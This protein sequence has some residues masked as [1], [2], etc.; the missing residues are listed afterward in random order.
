M[1]VGGHM[2]CIR[3]IELLIIRLLTYSEGVVFYFH[4]LS[5]VGYEALRKQ[6]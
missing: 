5:V 4:S 6:Y 1:K 2:H 3:V